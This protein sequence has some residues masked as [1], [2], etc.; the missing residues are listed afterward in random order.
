MQYLTQLWWLTMMQYLTQL[1]L[2][3]QINTDDAIPSCRESCMTHVIIQHTVSP[4]SNLN[5]NNNEKNTK[6]VQI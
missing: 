2:L 1:W 5:K 3:T 6:P 4:L